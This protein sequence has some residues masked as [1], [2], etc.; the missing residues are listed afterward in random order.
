MD[1]QSNSWL[2][3]F[4]FPDDI[5][6]RILYHLPFD[7][8]LEVRLVCRAFGQ[9]V[10]RVLASVSI[11]EDN[12]ESFELIVNLL[13]YLKNVSIIRH[14]NVGGSEEDEN[15]LILRLLSSFCARIRYIENAPVAFVCDYIDSLEDQ[16]K[17]IFINKIK[18]SNVFD[19]NSREL[20]ILLEKHLCIEVFIDELDLETVLSET[21]SDD[22][23]F[24]RRRI[25]GLNPGVLKLNS[26]PSHISKLLSSL[27]NLRSL[28]IKISIENVDVISTVCPHLRHLYIEDVESERESCNLNAIETF[29]QQRVPVLSSFSLFITST[30]PEEKV[31]HLLHLLSQS[32]ATF[33]L[34]PETEWL[35]C[36][37]CLGSRWHV[38]TK[39]SILYIKS[40]SLQS[41]Q[42]MLRLFLPVKR[43]QVEHVVSPDD[44]NRWLEEMDK[45]TRNLRLPAACVSFACITEQSM[46][47]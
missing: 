3:L 12:G 2:H 20:A 17:P 43:I 5:L 46:L 19:L 4:S 28:W 16:E 26:S 40:W 15:D 18:V 45:C 22:D 10:K 14:F 41:L 30:I 31:K 33:R 38:W 6:D 37:L 29:I 42:S 25:T 11:L 9:S 47:I 21:W 39:E 32:K 24:L 7:K 27:V 35:S 13:P 34:Y 1:S 36:D 8:L 23:E 44:K